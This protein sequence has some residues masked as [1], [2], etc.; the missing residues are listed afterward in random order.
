MPKDP[1]KRIERLR[2]QIR[3]ADKLYYNLGQPELTDAEYDVLFEELRQ[4]EEAHPELRT[5]DSPTVRV[6]APLAKGSS[7]EKVAHLA[8]MLSIESLQTEEDVREFEERARRQLSLGEDDQLRWA[9]EPK[10]DGV[11]ANLLYEN[12]ELMRG[13]SR[14]DGTHGEDIT[15]NLR[16]I[17]NLPL[18]L[19]GDG[20]F[21]A[22]G[23]T[24]SSADTS[25]ATTGA[26]L[27]R[28]P[29][30]LPSEAADGSSGTS[31]MTGTW[32]S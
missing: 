24:S 8:P 28:A 31:T 3:R 15:R 29:R 13:L 30:F 11:S 19:T 22:G 23:T 32:I 21:P 14:G 2:A 25:G 27:R 10:F 9:V 20:P 26:N 4:L 7:F 17:R 6:G 16:T 5:Q 1:R 18:Q 12:G